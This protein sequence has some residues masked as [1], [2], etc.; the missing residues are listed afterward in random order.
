MEAVGNIHAIGRNYVDHI[1]EL[2]NKMSDQPVIFSK[3]PSTLSCERELTFTKALGPIHF[4]LELVLRIGTDLDADSF[5][6]MDCISHMGLGIDFTARE[7]QAD[8]KSKGLPWSLAKNFTNATWL[9]PL[10]EGFD[11]SEPF[12]FR[13]AQNDQTRQQ[14]DSTR[15]IYPFHEI[16][17]FINRTMPL[18]SGDLIFTGTPAGVGPVADGDVLHVACPELLIDQRVIIHF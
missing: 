6:G 12:H 2:G 5:H 18:R 4:E 16:V 3:S 15:M 11:L 13:L 10:R 1:E 8:L 7:T 17:A 9:S 14:G